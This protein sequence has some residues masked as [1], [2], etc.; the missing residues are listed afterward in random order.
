[1]YF[2]ETPVFVTVKGPI[3]V[4][5]PRGI[6]VGDTFESIIAKFPQEKDWQLIY[7]G[8]VYGD[9]AVDMEAQEPCASIVCHWY[10]SILTKA[11]N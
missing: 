7:N 6:A 9:Q 10:L 4:Q 5:G 3:D 8:E 1:M 2:S 11:I